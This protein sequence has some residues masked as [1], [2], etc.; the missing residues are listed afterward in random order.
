MFTRYLISCP[1]AH[2]PPFLCSYLTTCNSKSQG[3][4]WFQKENGEMQS[5]YM[6]GKW[7]SRLYVSSS[8]EP[9]HPSWQK[10]D[11]G[12]IEGQVPWQSQEGHEVHG[13]V[14]CSISYPSM[15]ATCFCYKGD[16]FRKCSVFRTEK[17]QI[18]YNKV[19]K[20]ITPESVTFEEESWISMFPHGSPTY[21]LISEQLE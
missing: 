10:D 14:F 5:Y 17:T 11:Q 1:L 7:R 18:T 19:N 2:V 15:E 8:G 13:I 21:I 20:W 12:A 9:R 4:A 6:S 3:K 16:C